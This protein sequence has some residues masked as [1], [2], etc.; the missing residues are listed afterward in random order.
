MN[1]VGYSEQYY[2]IING[3]ISDTINFGNGGYPDWDNSPLKD[4][5]CY[6]NE[7]DIAYTWDKWNPSIGD[8]PP[9]K[10]TKQSLLEKTEI[11]Y[12]AISKI[13]PNFIKNINPNDKIS[14]VSIDVD[15]YSSTMECFEVFKA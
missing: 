8:Y 2:T 5:I 6:F 12:G 15:Y 9:G 3:T 14:F 10:L 11:F 1:L 13:V 7:K 4:Q